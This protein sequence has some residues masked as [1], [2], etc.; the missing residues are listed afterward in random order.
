MYYLGIS[1]L[2]LI[3]CVALYYGY[4]VFYAAKKPLESV[5]L[6]TGAQQQ[7]GLLVLLPGISDSAQ[8][9][10]QNGFVDEL[11]ARGIAL[12]VRYVDARLNYYL[13]MTVVQR[14]REDIIRPALA[15]G[16]KQIWL[17]GVSMGG[18]GSLLYARQYP[19]EVA[20][21]LALAPYLGKER[22][23]RK[24]VAGQGDPL[25]DTRYRRTYQLWQ[26]FGRYAQTPD[27]QPPLYLAYGNG[28]KFAEMNAYLAERLPGSHSLHIEGRHN[29]LTWK[30]LWVQLLDR[31]VFARPN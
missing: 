3:V 9:Y 7:S 11:S 17:A 12:D 18:F 29:W 19:Q 6:K 25:A 10:L 16:Y 27:L 30:K 31:G 21:V 22:I 2:G 23:I 26:W 28:D 5:V 4:R 1:L 8:D 15:R 20:G 13:A 24:I 14:L